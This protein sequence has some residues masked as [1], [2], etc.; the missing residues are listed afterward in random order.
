MEGEHTVTWLP[1]S[2]WLRVHTGQVEVI[3]NNL[4]IFVDRIQDKR[5]DTRLHCKR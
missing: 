5:T 3:G 2:R 4:K 1:E